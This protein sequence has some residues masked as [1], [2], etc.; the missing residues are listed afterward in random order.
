MNWQF[1]DDASWPFGRLRYPVP[2][3]PVPM[4]DDIPA[5]PFMEE[6]TNEYA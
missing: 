4:P 5:A 1:K 2:T 3:Q 6:Q